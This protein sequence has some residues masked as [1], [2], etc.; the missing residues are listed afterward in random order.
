M[1]RAI[2][3]CADD[4]AHS[5]P[6]SRAILELAANKRISALSC[7]TPSEHWRAH[8]PWLSD[9]RDRVD[10]GL[11]ITLVDEVPLTK[12]PHTAPDG[13]LPNI[14]TMILRSYLGLLDL[15]EIAVEIRA[16]I[17]AFESVLG[18]SPAH[19]D[20]HL[21]T[22]VLPG[23]RDVLLNATAKMNPRPWWRNINDNVP[24]ILKRGIAAPKAIFLSAL[25][26]RFAHTD[27]AMNDGFSGIYAF[28]PANSNYSALFERFVIAAGKQHLIMCHPGES[29]DDAAHAG[30]RGGEYAFLKSTAFTECLGRHD[31]R[32]GRFAET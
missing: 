9:V 30:L 13:R 11:H 10:I 22:H 32:L 7:M 12:M 2:I 24:G 8:G 5:L 15:Q 4:Y 23:I 25:G 17:D 31:L 18:F 27:V 1:S 26:R 6:I 29:G 3:L 21:H 20:G 28:S 16:Q 14:K 19:I